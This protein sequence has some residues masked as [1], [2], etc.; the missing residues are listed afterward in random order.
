[1]K[2]KIQVARIAGNSALYLFFFSL[3]VLFL[4]IVGS[5]QGFLDETLLLLLTVL[6]WV[7]FVFCITDLYYGIFSVAALFR[8]DKRFASPF[9][10]I[11]AFL[12]GAGMLGALNMMYSWFFW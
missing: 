11:L 6:E 3:I 4:Y 9:V 12:Y 10:A 7:L 5:L 1:M 8:G 2:E